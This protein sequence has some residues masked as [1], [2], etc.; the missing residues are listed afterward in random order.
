MLHHRQ[1][2]HITLTNKFSAPRLRDEIDALGRS[3]REHDLVCTRCA[4]VVC[5][6]PPR[7][8]VSL[9]CARTEQMQPTMHVG[10]LMLVKIPERLDHCPRFLRGCGAIEIDQGMP[11]RPLAE[12]REISADRIPIDSAGSNLVHTIICYTRRCAPLYSDVITGCG[13]S[14]RVQ[15]I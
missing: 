15:L 12:N 5:D 9:N 11:V 3:A 10:V 2:D 8:F 6:A 7:F 1:Q 4:D 13:C 14:D